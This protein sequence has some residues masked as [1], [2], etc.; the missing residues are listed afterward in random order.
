MIRDLFDKWL[1]E[2]LTTNEMWLK[3]SEESYFADMINYFLKFSTIRDHVLLVLHNNCY[4]FT[5]FF[6]EKIIKNIVLSG[7]K[8]LI[9][10]AATFYIRNN[11]LELFNLLVK[12]LVDI[13]NYDHNFTLLFLSS[14]DFNRADIT[15]SFLKSVGHSNDYLIKLL[16]DY[17]FHD[18]LKYYTASFAKFHI[19]S[20][21]DII[22]FCKNLHSFYVPILWDL[23]KQEY[24]FSMI[25]SL[26][27]N[28][29]LDFEYYQILLP[30]FE[31]RNKY[32]SYLVHS[33][34]SNVQSIS[35]YAN[36]LKYYFSCEF[37][38]F[39]EK[40]LLIWPPHL[41]N[42]FASVIPNCS[43]RKF[44]EKIFSYKDEYQMIRFIELNPEY[45]KLLPML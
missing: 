38:Y 32:A 37:D 25:F 22:N 24:Y 43:K 33:F 41:L 6:N 29:F 16:I 1:K 26:S 34:I 30:T 13:G 44:L 36:Y 27:E 31:L 5:H 40:I 18:K 14:N 45:K 15:Q 21:Y 39:E 10:T 9:N 42:L 20:R 12:E 23:N 28:T 19:G 35:S 2:F 17:N 4:R 8:E 3:Q 7:D 11:D